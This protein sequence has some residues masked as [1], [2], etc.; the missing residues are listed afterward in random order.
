MSQESTLASERL[1]LAALVSMHE[2]APPG[3]R[4]A[5]G[6]ELHEIDGVTVSVAA[7]EPNTLVNRAL[8][9]G[10]LAP[11]SRATVRAIREI[12]ERAGV[13]RYFLHVHPEAQPAELRTWLAEEGLGPYRRWAKFEYDTARAAPDAS[14]RFR[15]DQIDAHHADDFA[16]IA[17]AGFDF[18]DAAVPMIAALV[19]DSRWRLYMTFDGDEPVG[20]G[21]LF[22]DRAGDGDAA[23][24]EF[25]V[26]RPAY[27]CQGGQRQ[28]LARRLA[29]ALALGCRHIMTETGEWVEGDPQHSYKNIERS[30]FR[31]ACARDNYVPAPAPR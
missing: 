5:L 15:V 11:A 23:W 26:T 17:A 14:G 22:V 24:L 31:M 9:L 1:E 30:G 25:G 7:R 27:R 10:V 13:R 18:T 20:T 21:G 6:M 4:A 16:R 19:H 29:D 2:A 28:I 3:V 12:Y 8:G